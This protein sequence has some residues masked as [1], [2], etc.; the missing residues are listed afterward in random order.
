[1]YTEWL[2]SIYRA[3][4][5][6][7]FGTQVLENLLLPSKSSLLKSMKSTFPAISCPLQRYHDKT[8]DV[9]IAHSPT[10]FRK[11]IHEIKPKIELSRHIAAQSLIRQ[12]QVFHEF[13]LTISLVI[14]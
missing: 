9:I 3:V 10:V 4:P 6:P 5:S 11:K 13:L 12:P 2:A 1:M 7:A 14:S 8:I